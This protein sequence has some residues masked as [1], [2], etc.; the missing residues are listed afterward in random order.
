MGGVVGTCVWVFSGSILN[1]NSYTYPMSSTAHKKVR[2][3]SIQ[4]FVF[5][6]ILFLLLLTSVNIQDFLT[7]KKVLGAQTNISAQADKEN[8]FWNEFLSKNPNYI[9]GWIETGRT[10][11]VKEIDPNFRY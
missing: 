8:L 7:P 4:I 5:V 3:A 1:I 2:K 6:A 10:D 11:K 9:P